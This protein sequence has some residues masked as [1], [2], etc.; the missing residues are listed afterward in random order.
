MNWPAL[1]RRLIG[2]EGWGGNIDTRS[3][4]HIQSAATREARQRELE[5]ETTANMRSYLERTG[6]LRGQAA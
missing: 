5:R 3:P 1:Y 4:S 2:R 6:K